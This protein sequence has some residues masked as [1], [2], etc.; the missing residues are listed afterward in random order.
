MRGVRL[1]SARHSANAQPE[2]TGQDLGLGNTTSA[3]PTGRSPVASDG[4]LITV[5]PTTIVVDPPPSRFIALRSPSDL[6]TAAVSAMPSPTLD[7]L[8]P[9]AVT[10][11]VRPWAS[12]PAN[13]RG[14]RLCTQP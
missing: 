11:T 3:S 9:S 4:A 6:A 8:R 13:V 2:V 12:T 1:A 10:S 14:F 5:P 7:V